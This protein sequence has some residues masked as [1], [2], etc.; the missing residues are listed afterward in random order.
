VTCR[1]LDAKE[2]EERLAAQK[3][4]AAVAQA[5]AAKA[6]EPK[7]LQASE[8]AKLLRD[9]KAKDEWAVRNAADRLAKAPASGDA[10][11]FAAVLTP[12]LS[13]RNNWIRTSAAKALVNWATTNSAPALRT[14]VGDNDLWLRKAAMEALARFPSP[15]NAQAIAARL[16]ELGD[17]GDAVKA[18]E[19]I[20]PV[21]EPAVLAYLKDRDG[22]VRLEA[23]K[24]LGRIGTAKSLPALEEFGANGQGFDKPETEKAIQAIRARGGGS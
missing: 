21:A 19:T 8:R 3:A 7:P 14:A 1:L 16:L 23:C 5:A 17:R 4:E 11:E 12:L 13:D 18:L 6:N 22:W 24:L 15:E 9:L 2:T 20:G 10:E